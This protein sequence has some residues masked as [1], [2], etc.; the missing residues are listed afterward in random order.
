MEIAENSG[1]NSE[2]KLPANFEVLKG[3]QFKPGQSGNPGGRPKKKPLTEA[4]EAILNADTPE[5]AEHAVEIAKHMI[6]LAKGKIAFCEGG[7]AVQAAKFVAGQLGELAATRI[8]GTGK[9]GAIKVEMTVEEK[10]ARVAELINR[11]RARTAQ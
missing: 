8:E 2:K 6:Q 7:A 5:A 9:D 11:A 4:L 3:H 1:G 10:R